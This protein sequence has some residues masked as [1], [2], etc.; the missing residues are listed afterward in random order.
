MD[1]MFSLNMRESDGLGRYRD[2][3]D[4]KYLIALNDMYP[5]ILLDNSLMF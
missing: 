3:G 1:N 2:K 5:E 4:Q